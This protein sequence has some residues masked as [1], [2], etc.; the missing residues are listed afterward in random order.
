MAIWQYRLILLPSKILASREG[1]L[2]RNLAPSIAEEFSW[3][4]AYQP[5]A[6]F[7]QKIDAILPQ[8]DSWSTSMRMWGQKHAHEAW[9]CYED[10]SHARVEE[11]GFR[12]DVRRKLE[13]YSQ[14][15]VNLS[16]ELG[17]VLLTP[18]YDIVMPERSAVLAAIQGSTAKKF[19]HDP[20]AA[21]RSVDQKRFENDPQ[22]KE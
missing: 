11:I 19:L 2:P 18:E 15:I 12:I 8:S 22:S 9:V 16:S 21:L 6:G 20:I 1:S 17:C 5:P 7:E 14:A 3:W 13:E 10:E 4:A